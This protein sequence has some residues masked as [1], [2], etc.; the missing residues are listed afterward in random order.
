M[1]VSRVSGW[2][3]K[4]AAEEKFGLLE[5][6]FLYSSEEEFYEARGKLNPPPVRVTVLIESEDSKLGNSYVPNVREVQEAA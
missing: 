3:S 5:K 2:M 4:A 6:N 1:S